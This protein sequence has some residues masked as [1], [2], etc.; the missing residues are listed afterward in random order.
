MWG[1]ASLDASWAV[2]VRVIS[3][4]ARFNRRINIEGWF[5]DLMF[6]AVLPALLTAF[7]TH[8]NI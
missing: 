6:A 7:A 5:W 4:V 8:G 1:T 2:S 3:T